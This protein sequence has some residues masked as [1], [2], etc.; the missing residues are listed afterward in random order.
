M[1]DG[2][3]DLIPLAEAVICEDCRVI[4]RAKH[5]SCP[6]C[7]SAAIWNLFRIIE[8]LTQREIDRCIE[9]IWEKS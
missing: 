8:G 1:N 4:F 5:S 9:R 6:S 3:N 2:R 7:G